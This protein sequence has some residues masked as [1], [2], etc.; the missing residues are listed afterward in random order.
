[1][2]KYSVCVLKNNDIIVHLPKDQNWEICE[3]NLVFL[4][5]DQYSYCHAGV[6]GKPVNL[7]AGDGIQV[8]YT[9]MIEGSKRFIVRL[10]E[11]LSLI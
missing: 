1:M 11:Q 4:R 9:L 3:I 7:G 10:Q 2:D 8:P 5:G 6:K